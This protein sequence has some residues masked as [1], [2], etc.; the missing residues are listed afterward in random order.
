M[1][2]RETALGWKAWIQILALLFTSWV[3]LAKLLT[4]SVPQ[5]HL[6]RNGYAHYKG[7]IIVP[8]SLDCCGK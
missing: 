4:L 8:L 2:V 7:L 6:G 1:V 5:F 3:T